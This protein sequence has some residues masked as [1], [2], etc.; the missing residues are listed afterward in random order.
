LQLS[1]PYGSDYWNPDEQ[2]RII[3]ETLDQI[4]LADELG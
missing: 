2:Y 4:E 1:K 3:K